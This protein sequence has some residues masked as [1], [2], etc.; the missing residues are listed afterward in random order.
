VLVGLGVPNVLGEDSSTLGV[1]V[2]LE[3]V[4]TL[5]E[6]KTNGIGVG[7]DAVMDDRELRSEIGAHGVTVALRGLAVGRPASVGDGH[8]VEELLGGVDLS[9][10]NLLAKSSNLA[11]L[12]EEDRLSWLIAVDAN[13]SGIISAVL[14]ASEAVAKDLTDR[15]AVLRCSISMTS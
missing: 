9:L 1:G 5:L 6:N 12:L 11:D 13:A 7:D 10:R 3:V 15:L 8:L 14:L 4:T 2:R